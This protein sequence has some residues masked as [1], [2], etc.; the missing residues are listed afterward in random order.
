MVV[1][2]QPFRAAV[3]FAVWSKKF[4]M[5][6]TPALLNLLNGPCGSDPGFFI[7]WSRFWQLRR[8]LSNRPD[9]EDRIFRQLD[10]AS[11][12]PGGPFIS[13]LS[14]LRKL[15]FSGILSRPVGLGL[16]YLC[17]V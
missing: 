7:F 6:N 15:A 12:A 13:S 9:E 3:A 10:C 17:C 1:K 16:A 14:L 5:T 8:Y 4:P 11:T 2:V